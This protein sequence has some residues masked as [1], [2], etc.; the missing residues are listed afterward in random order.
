MA[1]SGGDAFKASQRSLLP[2]SHTWDERVGE[3]SAGADLGEKQPP[4]TCGRL[5]GG[6]ACRQGRSRVC[7]GTAPVGTGCRAA[8][9]PVLLVTS[10]PTERRLLVPLAEVLNCAETP[11]RCLLVYRKLDEIDFDQCCQRLPHLYS[12]GPRLTCDSARRDACPPQAEWSL[13]PRV[14]KQC[15][16]RTHGA[17]LFRD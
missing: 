7:L 4:G 12:A 17:P 11:R 2:M 13:N 10:A 8:F 16:Q 1:A 6:A 3:A 9:L 5:G 15:L 14:C